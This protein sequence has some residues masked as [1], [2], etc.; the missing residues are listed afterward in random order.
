MKPTD[1]GERFELNSPVELPSQWQQARLVRTFRGATFE[2]EMRRD[3][4]VATLQVIVD[5]RTLPGN[6]ITVITPG[7]T[8]KI[9]VKLPG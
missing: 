9:T 1:D 8:S 4:G 7:T 2:I 3:P 5:G 6:R